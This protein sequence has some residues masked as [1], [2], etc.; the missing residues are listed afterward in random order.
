M[1]IFAY[2]VLENIVMVHVYDGWELFRAIYQHPFS[3]FGDYLIG[4]N[5]GLI[6]F[7]YHNNDQNIP[8]RNNDIFY[9]LL[10]V[11]GM[12]LSIALIM[13]YI[14]RLENGRL[15][16]IQN[17]G[18]YFTIP[19]CML[20]YSLPYLEDEINKLKALSKFS[21]FGKF[22]SIAFFVHVVVI[23]Y[24]HAIYER[25]TAVNTMIWMIVSLTITVIVSSML[26]RWIAG[27]KR[28]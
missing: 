27:K 22:T 21:E 4:A 9:V 20:V 19:A 13:L 7:I 1:S 26:Y 6:F 18:F 12:L 28:I 10:S 11:S 23:N 5:A 15:S 24:V 2:I 17:S 8:S 25:I 16:W 14:L 3:R